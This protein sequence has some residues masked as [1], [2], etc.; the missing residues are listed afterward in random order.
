[1]SPGLLSVA[2]DKGLP[3]LSSPT[4]TGSRLRHQEL[5]HPILLNIAHNPPQGPQILGPGRQEKKPPGDSSG[6]FL[7]VS[8]VAVE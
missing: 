3:L 8:K 2:D 4:V 5:L 1:M 6:S 7:C